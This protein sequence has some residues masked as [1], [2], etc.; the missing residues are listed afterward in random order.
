MT[1]KLG[2]RERRLATIMVADIVGYSRLMDADEEG[3]YTQL[4]AARVEVIDPVRRQSI[5]DHLSLFL[6]GTFLPVVSPV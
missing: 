6:R 3:T 4:R 2:D 1:P 5:W